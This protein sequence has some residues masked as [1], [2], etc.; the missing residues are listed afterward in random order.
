MFR[1]LLDPSQKLKIISMATG[2]K[3]LPENQL[4]NNGAVVHD[5][6]AEVF[7]YLNL[8]VRKIEYFD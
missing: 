7:F 4:V 1:F 2:S 3:C 6:H 5:S 8:L